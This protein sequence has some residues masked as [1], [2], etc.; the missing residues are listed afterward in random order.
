[1]EKVRLIG[2]RLLVELEDEEE[3][4]ANSLIVKPETV[5][6]TAQGW[7]KVLGVG[8]GVPT[9]AGKVPIKGVRVGDRVAFVKF[10]KRTQ[11][12]E[13]LAH[14]LGEKNLIIEFKDV[15]VVQRSDGSDQGK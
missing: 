9:R 1:M 10:L 14:V 5:H 12:N 8:D 15:V 6:Q 3:F 11:A 4:F 13:A 7:G 2:P